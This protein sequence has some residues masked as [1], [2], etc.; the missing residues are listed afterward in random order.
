MFIFFFRIPYYGS[1]T[2]GYRAFEKHTVHSRSRFKKPAAASL[3]EPF[4]ADSTVC[5]TSFPQ[6]FNIACESFPY[7]PL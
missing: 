2:Q 7:A 3:P 5:L 6:L 1:E 4:K